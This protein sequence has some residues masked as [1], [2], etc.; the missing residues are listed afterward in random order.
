MLYLEFGVFFSV[1][2]VGAPVVFDGFGVGEGV[3]GS[4]CEVG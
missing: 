4:V 1:F 2:D 3:V